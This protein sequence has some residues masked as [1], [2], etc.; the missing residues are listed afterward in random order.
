MKT[1]IKIII[2]LFTM[3]IM[4]V[5]INNFSFAEENLLASISEEEERQVEECDGSIG[6][7]TSIFTS[8]TTGR[9]FKEFKQ[10]TNYSYPEVYGTYWEQECGTVVTGIVGSGYKNLTM[11]DL[12]DELNN[13]ASQTDFNKFLGD[14]T[15]QSVQASSVSSIDEFK[16]A[17][18]NGSV[19]VIHD[20]GYNSRGHYLAVLD[21]SKDK[22]QVYVSN[23]DTY[24]NGWDGMSTGWIST[25]FVYN[26]I[27][28]N[29]IY[30]VTNDQSGD[31]WD[32]TTTV[33]YPNNEKRTYR[34]YK[35]YE[36]T[37]STKTYWGGT[38][39]TSG[40]GPTCISIILSGYGIDAN[41]G[42]VVDV[43]TELGYEYT[44]MENIKNVLKQKY[45][46]DSE[47]KNV[48]ADSIEDIKN[49]FNAGRPIIAGVENHF[50]TYLGEDSG[51]N[52]ILSDPG[53]TDG[54]NENTVNG[55][56]NSHNGYQILL[57]KTDKIIYEKG[58]GW[59]STTTVNYPNNEKRTYRNYKQYE[60]TYST[61]TYWGGTIATSGCGPTCISIIL[62][63]YGIDAN[64]GK[65]VD[66]FTELG[67]EY[68]SMEN[69][70][71]VLKQ[72]YNIDSEIKN[73]TA[74]SIEDIKNNF[75]AGRPIIA[76]VEN[77]FVTYL[78]EDSGG[79]MILSDPGYTDGRNEN[80]VNG[81]VNSHNGYQILLIKTG[82]NP[83]ITT[84][85]KY[86]VK[87]ENNT[88]YLE[89]IQINTT[90]K[91][92][93]NNIQTNGTIEIYTGNTKIEDENR[94]IG[95]GMTIKIKLDS[96]QEIYK[97]V[98]VGDVTGDGKISIADVLKLARYKAGSDKNLKEEYFKAGDI[99]K[100]NKISMPDVLKLARVLAKLDEIE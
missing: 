37:Y 85:K 94:L 96:K 82:N 22:S 65:V 95:T 38:I 91:E 1:I 3:L 70:K 30:F 81:Y 9:Q 18:L 13:N 48:T 44:S 41:P 35:Q 54:R 51:G 24:A 20:Y 17:L 60:G 14:F 11:Q 6:G 98:V 99:I 28:K 53:Y 71:N 12:A 47:I 61:K 58:D 64:P 16:N 63:G 92:L 77:H 87:E 27:E 42:K 29:E 59:D 67:Y 21:I 52:M 84:I 15:G 31:G 57:I 93:K 36:G 32:S 83:L 25:D 7:Y 79:N 49:N 88:K 39:A 45:N 68:T 2:A 19:A 72:K 43:F 89:N 10:N 80:T 62:S 74:D 55:Y 78:G 23:P 33:N 8:R 97:T 5:S 50:V 34:N 56:V 40:C 4:I 90:I 69:I 100:D 76:G 46:I 66:V 75:N 86:E 26:A 73:V